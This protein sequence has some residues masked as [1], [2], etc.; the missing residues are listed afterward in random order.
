MARPRR[1]F[2]RLITF[3]RFNRAE[4]E[5]AREVESHLALMED[6]FRLK[7]M[8]SEEA[9]L[10]A[11]RAFGGVEHAKDRH[12]DVRSFIWLDDTRRDVRYALRGL[13]KNPG[14]TVVAVLTLAFGIGANT[15]I[16]SLVNALILRSLPVDHPEQL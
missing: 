1:F 8:T 13:V 3:L 14:F 4:D 6:E 2:L 7:G 5:L 15:A 9:R 16:F 11:R 10:A 12:R